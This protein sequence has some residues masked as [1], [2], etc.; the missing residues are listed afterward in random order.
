[1]SISRLSIGILSAGITAAITASVT[2]VTTHMVEQRFN[3]SPAVQSSGDFD[4]GSYDQGYE[5]FACACAPG[6]TYAD[7]GYD[8]YGTTDIDPKHAAASA[9]QGKFRAPQSASAKQSKKKISIA[10]VDSGSD[11]GWGSADSEIYDTYRPDSGGETATH[12][13]H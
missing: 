1:M 13:K 11:D 2:V 8:P 5:P 7:T 3:T 9:K 12:L 10:K 6:V 4:L